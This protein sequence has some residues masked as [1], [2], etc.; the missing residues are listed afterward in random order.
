MSI[1]CVVSGPVHKALQTD[2]KNALT[3]FT[4]A[5]LV[6]GLAKIYDSLARLGVFALPQCDPIVNNGVRRRC[7]MGKSCAVDTTT[8][9]CMC[10]CMYTH[11]SLCFT[12]RAHDAGVAKN[13][14]VFYAQ[15][16]ARVFAEGADGGLAEVQ[17]AMTRS[18][19]EIDTLLGIPPSPLGHLLKA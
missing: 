11:M 12:R 5:Q 6:G 4:S 7:Q 19:R 14:S 15:L 9:M 17:A 13:V 8:C 2:A 1:C 3:P 10:M 18:P 16:H